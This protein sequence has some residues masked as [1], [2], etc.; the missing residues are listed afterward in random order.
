MIGDV[1]AV[2]ARV[3]GWRAAGERVALVPTMGALHA[4]HLS[5]VER[6]RAAAD[7]TIVSI[8]VNPMQFAPNEDLAR[9]PRR[10]AEDRGL[11][12][13]LGVDAVFAPS[14]PAVYPNG[15]ATSI[16]VAG[17]GDGFE[18]AARPGHFVGVATVVAKLLLMTA[19]DVAI[20]GEKD[21]QQLAIIR[22]MVID[23]DLPV[24]IVA[25]P[26]VRDADGLAL[27]SRNIY[28]SPEQRRAA[29]ALP[30]ALQQAALAIAGGAPVAPALQAAE[31]SLL[32]A[33]FSAVDYV[34]LVDERSLCPVD[35][36]LPGSRLLA[37]ATIGSTRLLDN[38]TLE[39]QP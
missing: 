7:R 2:R 6:A 32:S 15:F 11:L 19:P 33:G 39:H 14:V 10:E 4:G 37:A 21:W 22:R 27:S 16:T 29:L 8:F 20:F 12:Q 17:L 1:A 35:A 28:L 23:L 38:L 9:Y 34:S 24:E 18:G 5:L 30:Q 13:T 31:A 25:G 3:R 36:P 26:I